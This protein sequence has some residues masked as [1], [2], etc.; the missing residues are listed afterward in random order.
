MPGDVDAS[1]LIEAVRVR[2]VRDAAPGQAAGER[3]SRRCKR[4]VEMGAPW[5]KEEAPTAD[6]ARPEFDLQQ[7]KV[8]ALGLATGPITA[9]PEVADTQ[10]AT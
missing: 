1:L 9:I 5:P 2:I 4:W 6:A 8:G 3:H 10:M 7:R